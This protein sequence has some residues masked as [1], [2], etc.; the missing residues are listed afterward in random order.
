MA[1][2]NCPEC[3]KE[4][5]DRAESCPHCGLPSKYFIRLLENT[6]KISNKK[7]PIVDLSELRNV[8]ISFDQSYQT[9][10][11][12]GNYITKSD[13][14]KLKA[15]FR[16]W[17]EY[18]SDKSIYDY[19]TENAP[20]YSI[21]MQ[22][23][24]SCLK[25]YEPLAQDVKNHNAQY[26]ETIVEQ[27]KEYFDNL[28]KDID[29]NIMLDDEQR[30]AVVTDDDYC[31]LVAGAGAGKTTTMAAKVKYLVEKKH[32]PPEEIIVISY[33][34]KTIDELKD[35]INKG[36]N[37]PSEICTFHKFA[38]GI[39]RKFSD[40][41]PE[42]Y[43][44]SYHY[45]IEMLE[46]NIFQDKILLRKVLHFLGYYFDLPAD[47]MEYENLNLFHLAKAAQDYETI[48]SG[49]GDYL[50]KVAA[51]RGSSMRTLTG[52]IPTFCSR[53]SNCK[54]FILKWFRL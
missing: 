22:L 43:Y 4:I 36:L 51:Q 50:K 30:R 20:K 11:G 29:P 28:L 17:A 45:I 12:I 18:L 44:S 23:L 10:F 42:V 52:G 41:P 35:R 8:L 54:F 16:N 15:S 49:A 21:D 2:I 26:I 40:N 3:S 6:S 19:C 47:A 48:K 25:R 7:E 38:Y 39:V 37:I 14:T 34:N 27:N 13:F 33:T 5:S 32:V 1:L 31:L 46:K 53:N 24:N 9:F